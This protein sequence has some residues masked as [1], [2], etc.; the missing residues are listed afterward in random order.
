MNHVH[1]GLDENTKTVTEHIDQVAFG[2]PKRVSVRRR[3]GRVL[4][5]IT[6]AEHPASIFY[7]DQ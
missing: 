5:F 4:T 6:A 1:V 2:V 3:L 7:G